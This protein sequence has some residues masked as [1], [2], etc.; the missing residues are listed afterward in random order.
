MKKEK[1]LS[2]L[3]KKLRESTNWKKKSGK[4]FTKWDQ[5]LLDSIIAQDLVDDSLSLLE[6]LDVD[7]DWE[8]LQK[9]L[10]QPKVRTLHPKRMFKYAAIF[11]GFISLG[12]TYK[13]IFN[14]TALDLKEKHDGNYVTL[15][16]GSEVISI[17][18]HGSHSIELATGIKV[19][20]QN[21]DTLIY[22]E[23]E[24]IGDE[25][26]NELHIPNGKVF[27]LVLSDGTKI[28]LNSGSKVRFPVKFPKMGKREVFVYGEAYFDV[29]RDEEHPF[30]VNSGEIGVEVLGTEFNISSYEEQSQITTVLIEGSVS[31]NHGFMNKKVLL[32]PGEKGSWD[33]S[34]SLMEVEEVNTELYTGWVK[35]E[36]I[37]R[38]ASF[39]ELFASL[40]RVYD[41]KIKNEN[42]GIIEKTINA[43]FNRN[44]EHI[45]E[46]LEALKVIVPFNYEI[47]RQNAKINQ[48]TILQ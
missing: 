37:F 18:D 6:N 29:T 40:E 33:K 5:D 8:K 14:D 20:V 31:L 34:K 46:V 16:I 24:A 13:L 30:V 12:L 27:T 10:D 47:R 21:G 15:D 4:D 2:L 28:Q 48:I 42:N 23:G 7:G 22:E 41:V 32:V 9:R 3:L 38:D 26:F 44:V 17:D 43:R 1:T 45:E 19:A 25:V 35:G 36:I 39:S 11:L